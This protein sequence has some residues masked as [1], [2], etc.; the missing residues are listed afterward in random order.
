MSLGMHANFE[1]LMHKLACVLVVGLNCQCLKDND[2]KL[3][4]MLCGKSSSSCR[5]G[6]PSTK[7]LSAM[8][9]PT[10]VIHHDRKL[11]RAGTVIFALCGT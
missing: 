10:P 4:A 6:P 8:M 9:S 3:S 2:V 1:N 11:Q 7:A 5:T